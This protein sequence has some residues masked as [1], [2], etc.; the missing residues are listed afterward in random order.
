MSGDDN[1]DEKSSY[2]FTTFARCNTCTETVFEHP[3]FGCFCKH[4]RSITN[5]P[6]GSQTSRVSRKFQD[7]RFDYHISIDRSKYDKLKQI[8]DHV[9]F[10][11][12]CI[13]EQRDR[14]LQLNMLT[15]HL[16]KN[17]CTSQNFGL[18][19]HYKC[20]Q[21]TSLFSIL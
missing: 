8:D 11:L 17:V 18:F 19:S 10:F 2:D 14:A 13:I 1:V 20:Y 6:L 21:L 16:M 5:P 15:N 7:N 9:L 12:T 4:K 3:V